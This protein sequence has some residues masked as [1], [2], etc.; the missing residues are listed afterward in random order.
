VLTARPPA[1]LF[2]NRIPCPSDRPVQPGC[3]T[4]RRQLRRDKQVGSARVH[5]SVTQ[6][7]RPGWIP[8]LDRLFFEITFV[9]AVLRVIRNQLLRT[10]EHPSQMSANPVDAED[11][12]ERNLRQFTMP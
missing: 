7:L 2:G 11:K 5:P 1:H 6:P 10:V 3:A 4:R 9:V 12:G 8:V